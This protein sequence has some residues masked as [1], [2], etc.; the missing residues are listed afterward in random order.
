MTLKSYSCVLCGQTQC[1]FTADDTDYGIHGNFRKVPMVCPY[2]QNIAQ[3]AKFQETESMED[4]DAWLRLK[5]A[6]ACEDED[7]EEWEKE[8]QRRMKT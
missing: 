3:Q 8:K 7:A 2:S 5:N 6:V 1:L 4:N